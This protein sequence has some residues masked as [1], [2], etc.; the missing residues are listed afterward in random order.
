MEVLRGP[1]SVFSKGL[2][3]IVVGVVVG[4][5]VSEIVKREGIGAI[6]KWV[7]DYMNLYGMDV[8]YITF[9]ITYAVSYVLFLA[10]ISSFSVWFILRAGS[11]IF[12]L[13]PANQ[14]RELSDA[15]EILNLR[16]ERFPIVTPDPGL[17]ELSDITWC[18][19]ERICRIKRLPEAQWWEFFNMIYRPVQA[20]DIERVKEIHG[21]LRAGSFRQNIRGL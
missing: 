20:G 17:I 4:S 13:L 7:S 8:R 16:M 1:L 9:S 21:R 12:A 5:I 2:G 15:L 3:S 6:S 10:S 14:L 18:E 19:L 11:I